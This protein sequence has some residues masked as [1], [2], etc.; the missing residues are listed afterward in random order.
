MD[1]LAR[2]EYPAMLVRSFPSSPPPQIPGAWANLL[3]A[4]PPTQAN[5]QPNQAVQALTDR[6][7]RINKIHQEVAD[8]ILVRDRP[9]VLEPQGPHRLNRK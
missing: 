3:F 9:Q 8:W 4:P 7:K 2:S 5:L 6:V 1:D